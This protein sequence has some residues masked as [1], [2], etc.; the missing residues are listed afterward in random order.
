MVAAVR[1]SGARAARDAAR[2]RQPRRPVGARAV[3]PGARG[4]RRGSAAPLSDRHGRRLRRRARPGA[5]PDSATSRCASTPTAPAST[6]P[7]SSTSSAAS[8]R[9]SPRRRPTPRA[10]RRRSTSVRVS[11]AADVALNY[12]E[13]RGIQQQLSVLDRS[14]VNQRET[15]RLTEVRRD[16]GIGEEQDVASASARVVGDRGGAAAAAHRARRARTS[17]GRAHRPGAGATDGRPRAAR[18]PRAREVD[19]ARPAGP[20]PQPPARRARRRTPAGARP[21]R[22]RAW[23][24]PTSIRASPSPACSACSPAA[25]TSSAPSDSRAWAV[26]PALQWSAFD[27]GSARAR[28]R[29]AHAATAEALA[30]LRDRRCCWRSRR[31][32]T[33]SSPIASGRS[34]SSS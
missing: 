26:T 8:A 12:F 11:V 25:A 13:L 24:P 34:G 20:A 27:L 29:G 31:R 33:R 1:R 7:G 3:R 6:R 5:C 22:E 2:R 21:R 14:L 30:E 17:A 19:R 28:L 15:L 32:R 10:S 18:L 9:R 16:A 4:L 23:P